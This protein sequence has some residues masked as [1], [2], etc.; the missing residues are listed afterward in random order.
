VAKSQVE[1]HPHIPG[2]QII[3]RIVLGGSDGVIESVATA[4]ALNGAGL[5]FGTILLAGFAFAAAGGLSMFF[6]SYLSRRSELDSLRIDMEREK[7]EIETEPEEERREL[8]EL[9]MKEGYG[10]DEVKVIMN[11]LMRD[12]DMW[13]RAQLRHELNLNT[14]ELSS[15]TLA[16]AASA[17]TAFFL[18]AMLSLTP[19]LF[20][21]SSTS[22]LLASVALS[23]VALFVLGSKVFTIRNFRLMGG[24][25]SAMIGAV[26]AGLLYFAGHLLASL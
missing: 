9:L 21:L 8:E 15:N 3:D 10:Q 14:E 24:L 19:Y 18:L 26:A 16:R 22:A 13:L 2:R 11:R 12:K 7:L 5:R 6:S 23:L 25:E 1:K 17:G 4:S 20:R